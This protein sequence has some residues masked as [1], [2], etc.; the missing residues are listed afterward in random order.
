[1]N[2]DGRNNSIG[3]DE[4]EGF[5]ANDTR[6]KSTG[7]SRFAPGEQSFG[8]VRERLVRVNDADLVIGEMEMAAGQRRFRHVAAHA[9]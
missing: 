2:K 6:P 3:A 1:M 5:N 4:K 9:F 8:S 7:A